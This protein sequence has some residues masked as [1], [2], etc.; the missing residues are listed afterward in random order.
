MVTFVVLVQGASTPK[1]LHGDVLTVQGTNTVVQLSS[2]ANLL[3]FHS[4]GVLRP[5][6]SSA[7]N[8]TTF[9]SYTWQMMFE[10]VFR[11]TWIPYMERGTCL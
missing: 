8:Y 7:A 6:I 10:M 11:A 4:S 9:V 5:E 3:F 2:V 1:T